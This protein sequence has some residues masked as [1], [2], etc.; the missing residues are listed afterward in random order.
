[1]ERNHR[2]ISIERIATPEWSYKF[3]LPGREMNA[4]LAVER[5]FWEKVTF[6]KRLASSR[7]LL[8]EK[9]MITLVLADKQSAGYSLMDPMFGCVRSKLVFGAKTLSHTVVIRSN[10]M[11][12]SNCLRSSRL[13]LCY[14]RPRSAT[15]QQQAQLARPSPS[16]E[17]TSTRLLNLSMS[18]L[19]R[20]VS[21]SCWEVFANG[22]R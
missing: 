18:R 12:R 22:R 19:L 10:S 17:L 2:S 20:T 6:Y 3:T 5:D 8:R 11:V 21:F 7:R 1:M 14:S 13:R 4:N 16:L 15:K 9:A